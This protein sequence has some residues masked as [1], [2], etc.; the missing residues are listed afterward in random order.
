MRGSSAKQE[1][2]KLSE[3]ISPK[4]TKSKRPIKPEYIVA[5]I[6]VVVTIV[7]GILGSPWIEKKISPAPVATQTITARDITTSVIHPV[8]PSITIAVSQIPV[9][10]FTPT[11]TPL[12]SLTPAMDAGLISSSPPANMDTGLNAWFPSERI[13]CDLGYI[14]GHSYIEIMPDSCVVDGVSNKSRP[15]LYNGI[16]TVT[17]QTENENPVKIVN[18]PY[19]SNYDLDGYSVYGGWILNSKMKIIFQDPWYY[20]SLPVQCNTSSSSFVSNATVGAVKLSDG[21]VILFQVDCR[22]SASN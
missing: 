11:F 8:T 1:F 5:I 21:V 19:D 15:E 3:Q 6:G 18:F 16:H 10:A 13:L 17:V 9:Q 20:A 4:K 2:L 22:G 7:A 12:S 14:A